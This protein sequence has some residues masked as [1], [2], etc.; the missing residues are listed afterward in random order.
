MKIKY[1]A[2]TDTLYI[3]FRAEG[4]TESRDLDE[5]TVVDVDADGNVLAIT[6]EH[7]STRTDLRNLTLEGI[8]A[9]A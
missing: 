8:G 7:A 5:N 4:I 2:E 9:A 1:F 3:E 6:F